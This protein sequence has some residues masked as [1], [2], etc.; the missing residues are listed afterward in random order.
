MSLQIAKI[1]LEHGHSF[2]REIKDK[3]SISF[4]YIDKVIWPTLEICHKKCY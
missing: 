1:V 3:E 4:T 2:L